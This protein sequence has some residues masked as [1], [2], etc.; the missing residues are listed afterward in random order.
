MKKL[1]IGTE[2]YNGIFVSIDNILDRA[3]NSVSGYFDSATSAYNKQLSNLSD[4][5]TRANAAIESYR[6]R[7]ENKFSSMDLLIGKIQQQYSSFLG[8]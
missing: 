3:L 4:K 2:E 7:L 5:I 6:A 1:L 8:T